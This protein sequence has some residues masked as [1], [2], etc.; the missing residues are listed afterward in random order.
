[1]SECRSPAHRAER[2][3]ERDKKKSAC[4]QPKKEQIDAKRHA[5]TE[6]VAE[7]RTLDFEDRQAAG[8]VVTGHGKNVRN[9]T[10]NN[11]G[12]HHGILL[13]VCQQDQFRL[14]FGI[15]NMVAPQTWFLIRQHGEV[16][17]L[18]GLE[19]TSPFLPGHPSLCGA[20]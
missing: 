4:D 16:Y 17:I 18:P 19:N 8:S 5:A 3:R 1:M 6:V 14:V 10:A 13:V 2:E 11:H 9:V 20:P 7:N 15:L 12:L